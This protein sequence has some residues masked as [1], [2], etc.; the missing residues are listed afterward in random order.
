MRRAAKRDRVET[1]IVKALRHAGFSVEYLSGTD[2]P[3][4]LLG[5]NRVCALAEV[6]TGNKPLRQGQ[7]QW[8]RDWQGFPPFILRSL[9]DAVALIQGWPAAKG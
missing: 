7:A 8:H 3:D 9:E 2:I 4:L 5:K 1:E 6:K